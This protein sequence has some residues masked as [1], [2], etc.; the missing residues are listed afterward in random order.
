MLGQRGSPELKLTQII[1][2][3]A[4]LCPQCG[5]DVALYWEDRRLGRQFLLMIAGSVL[6]GIVAFTGT[7]IYVGFPDTYRLVIG[8]WGFTILLVLALGW[9]ARRLDD[10]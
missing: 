2:G 8:S 7:M 4:Y 3:S 10:E 6:G 1:A 5:T 9:L